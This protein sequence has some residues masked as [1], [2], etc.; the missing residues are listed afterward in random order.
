MYNEEIIYLIL[1][2][3]RKHNDAWVEHT[4]TE[5][6][7]QEPWSRW[8]VDEIIGELKL[9][10]TSYPDEIVRR[11]IQRMAKYAEVAEPERRVLYATAKHTA[12]DLYSYLF[13]EENR[14]RKE[15]IPF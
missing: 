9:D 10:Q 5:R 2:Y 8:A 1:E 4:R 3:I 11:F 14:N 12:E 7:V 6:P 15:K 13:G